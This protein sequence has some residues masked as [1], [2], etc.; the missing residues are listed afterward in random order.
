[1]CC[2]RQNTYRTQNGVNHLRIISCFTNVVAVHWAC[3]IQSAHW[4]KDINVIC[5]IPLNTT[6]FTHLITIK[7]NNVYQLKKFIEDNFHCHSVGKLMTGLSWWTLMNLIICLFKPI[8]NLIYLFYFLFQ[9]YKI[10]LMNRKGD[11]VK[12]TLTFF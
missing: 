8:R 7:L 3:W 4:Q 2:V 6:W 9:I 12:T 10:H 5:Y 11:P 1:M